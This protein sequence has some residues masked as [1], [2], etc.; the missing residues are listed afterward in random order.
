MAKLKGPCI[1]TQ[2]SGML[3]DSL[4]YTTWKGRAYAKKLTVPTN[5]NTFK[6]QGNRAM[7]RFLSMNFATLSPANIASWSTIAEAHKLPV[8]N[9]FCSINLERWT[10]FFMPAKPYPANDGAPARN[11]TF[12]LAFAALRGLTIAITSSPANLA[13]GTTLHRST[14]PGFNP[15]PAN[16]IQVLFWPWSASTTLEH[17]DPKLKPGTYYYRVGSFS[18]SGRNTPAYTAQFSGTVT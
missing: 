10:R 2:A 11:I 6:Q 14:T 18:E 4:I 17:H 5:P 3:G 9:I 8:Y 16:C 13:W 1:S 12:A 15:S 7:L